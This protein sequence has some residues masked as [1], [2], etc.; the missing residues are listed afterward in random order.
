LKRL[1]LLESGILIDRNITLNF[2]NSLTFF[3]ISLV[4]I[5][6]HKS[7]SPTIHEE[8]SRQDRKKD[9]SVNIEH[10]A[11]YR[12]VGCMHVYAGIAVKR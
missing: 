6:Y 11:T 1:S 5:F 3:N 9:H 12:R 2:I 4:T 7:T 10:D 8:I